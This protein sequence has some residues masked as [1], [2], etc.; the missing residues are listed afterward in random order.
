M[1][2]HPSQ[3]TYRQLFDKAEELWKMVSDIAEEKLLEF[4]ADNA[5]EIMTDIAKKRTIPWSDSDVKALSEIVFH[6][7]EV[8]VRLD[9]MELRSTRGRKE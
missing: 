6:L 9:A 5:F 3:Q 2:P 8:V 7:S 4:V 1:D